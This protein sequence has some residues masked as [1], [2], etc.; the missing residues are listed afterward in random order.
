MDDLVK[1]LRNYEGEYHY[2]SGLLIRAADEIERL[3]AEINYLNTL[4][5]EWDERWIDNFS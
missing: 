1:D 4:L 3:I 5:D 2:P